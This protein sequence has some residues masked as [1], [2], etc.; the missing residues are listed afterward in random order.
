MPITS[1]GSAVKSMSEST[2]SPVPA[3]LYLNTTSRNSTRPA[4]TWG[5]PSGAC[6]TPALSAMSTSASSTST[7]RTPLAWARADITKIIEIIITLN[8][9]WNT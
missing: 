9:I 5:P 8:R 1:P 7:T 4:L 2:A 3:A 6:F